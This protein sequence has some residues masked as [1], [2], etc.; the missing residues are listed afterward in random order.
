MSAIDNGR[1][2]RG[3]TLLESALIFGPFIFMI[4]GALDFAQ[5]LYLHQTLTEQARAG[6]RYGAVQQRDVATDSAL[7]T[8]IQNVVIYGH[9]SAPTTDDTA[10]F[11]LTR[12]MVDVSRT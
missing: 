5:F 11:G 9:A 10:A 4:I 8:E 2:R 3:S 7:Q 12:A 6:A 1:K